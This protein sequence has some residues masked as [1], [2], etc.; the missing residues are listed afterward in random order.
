[1]GK[2]ANLQP[3]RVFQYF[4]EIAAIPHG[5]GNTAAI[6]EYC[7]TF[8]KNHGLSVDCDKIGNVIIRKPATKG[9]ENHPTVILQGHLDM[10]C[11]KSPQSEHDFE[12]DGLELGVDGDWLFANG[13]TLGGDDG[14]AAAMALAILE[15]DDLSHPPLEA[16][17]TVDEE[18]GL[19]GAAALDGTMLEGRVLLNIDS[20]DEGVLTVSCAGGVR[21]DVSLPIEY[22]YNSWNTYKVTVDGLLGGHSG[23]EID[24]GRLNA[25]MVIGQFLDT[26]ETYRIVRIEG[27][28]K[29]NVIPR[30]ATCILTATKDITSLG[31]EFAASLCT[32]NDP[33]LT[34]TV[35]HAVAENYMMTEESTRRI[36]RFLTTVPNGIVSMSEEIDGLVQTSLNMGILK[37]EEHAVKIGFGLRSSVNAE[38]CALL[39]RVR[40]TAEECDGSC[41]SHGDYPAW[42]FQ[43]DSRLRDT[44]C[45]VW[46]RLYG[47]KPKV[48]AIHAGL[49]CGFLCEKLAG[50][51]AV[52]IGP[53]MQ[54]IHTCEERLSISSTERVYR[55]VCE[56]LRSL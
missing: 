51:D 1:M 19:L 30:K 12:K 42:E 35:E 11:E 27:G 52:S 22:E 34:V 47:S 28:Q 24:K 44:M 29:D 13:T 4:E 49:E 36:V 9:Y 10:V 5:S 33:D 46:E 53:D 55:Y 17:F 16:L 3:A 40:Q 48:V 43:K 25:N 26:L 7:V 37:T 2:L 56:I 50:L 18:I 45:A 38:K 23:V 54:D 21:A 6:S 41:I 39:D 15:A 32:E 31:E 20:E 8:A 14:I